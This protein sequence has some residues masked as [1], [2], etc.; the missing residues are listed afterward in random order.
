MMN[1]NLFTMKSEG[2]KNIQAFT[3]GINKILDL[4]ADIA[5]L[6]TNYYGSHHC[7]GLSFGQNGAKMLMIIAEAGYFL[8]TN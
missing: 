3:D 4:A 6:M 2:T 1:V 8:G 7:M 5:G